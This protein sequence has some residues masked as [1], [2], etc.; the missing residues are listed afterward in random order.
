M[1][2]KKT[3]ITPI[4]KSLL[5]SSIHTSIINNI[6]FESIYSTHVTA[7]PTMQEFVLFVSENVVPLLNRTE[8]I[9]YFIKYYTL[10]YEHD[11]HGGRLQHYYL[12]SHTMYPMVTQAYSSVLFELSR[13]A[14]HQFCDEFLFAP[15]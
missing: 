4:D 6:P 2:V 10:K 8:W 12:W 9:A 14:F 7:L 1:A 5:T 13:A 3:S 15:T 11:N